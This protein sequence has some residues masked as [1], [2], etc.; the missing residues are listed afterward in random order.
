MDDS[1]LVYQAVIEAK[2]TYAASA[3]WGCGPLTTGVCLTSGEN[4]VAY[5]LLIFLRR[6]RWRQTV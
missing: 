3:W 6:L 2:L 1:S 4:G 5:V